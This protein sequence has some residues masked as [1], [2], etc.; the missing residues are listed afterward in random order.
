MRKLSEGSCTKEVVLENEELSEG[1]CTK[2]VVLE[3]EETVLQE[4]V[5]TN[6]RMSEY[7]LR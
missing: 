5:L 1:S 3:N 7:K 2:E 6:N 4:T